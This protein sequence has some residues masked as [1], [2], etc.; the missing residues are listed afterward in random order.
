MRHH[1]LAGLAALCLAAPAAALS[2]S[3]FVFFGDS[4]IDA[5]VVS[6]FTGGLVPDKSLGYWAGRFSEGPTWADFLGYANFGTA[7][8]AFNVGNPAFTLPPPFT[9][10]ATNFAVGGAR[11]SGDDVQVLGT[12]PGLNSQLGLFQ[13]YLLTTGQAFD[14]NAL[15]VINFG[16]NDVNFID[17]LPNPVDKAMVANAYV[18]NMAG[19][20][21]GLAGAGAQNILI[22][23][24]PNPTNPTGVAL[25]AALDTQLDFLE[26]AVLPPSVNLFRF[27]YFNFFNQLAID[28]TVYRLPANLDL[29]TPCLAVVQPGPGIDCTGFLSFDGIHVTKAVQR[30][31]SIEIARLT[32]LNAVPEPATWGMMIAGFGLVGMA[33]RRRRKEVACA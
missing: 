9:P 7:T 1:L 29:T 28:P 18:T 10:G 19:A 2:P 15:Y 6:N 11:A 22:L 24:V 27:D 5:G 16:N 3:Q 30:A 4:F 31:L 13:L 23:G 20:V 17:S 32:G 8:R 25:Q 26:Q 33:A 12:I 14:P 21:L